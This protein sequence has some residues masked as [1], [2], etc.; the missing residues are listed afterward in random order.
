MKEVFLI[1]L[2][3]YSMMVIFKLFHDLLF[4]IT[5]LKKIYHSFKNGEYSLTLITSDNTFYFINKNVDDINSPLY[6]PM[7]FRENGDVYIP[8]IT[9]PKLLM[10]L[11]SPMELYWSFKIE[12]HFN[13]H[14]EVLK[15]N[16]AECKYSELIDHLQTI[17]KNEK[18]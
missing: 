3:T 8:Y 4:V 14:K 11:I 12:N 1:F 10:V 17:V 15:K 5:P 16:F 7:W 9:Q 6:V 18:Y 2:V 13:E